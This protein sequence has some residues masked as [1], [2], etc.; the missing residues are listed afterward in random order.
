MWEYAL[1]IAAGILILMIVHCLFFSK[2][3]NW[4]DDPNRAFRKD[5][6]TNFSYSPVTEQQHTQMTVLKGP[7]D[8]M[9]LP[10]RGNLPDLEEQMREDIVLLRKKLGT[11]PPPGKATGVGKNAGTYSLKR[12]PPEKLEPLPP[13]SHTILDPNMAQRMAKVREMEEREK[14]A[15]ILGLK[16]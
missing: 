11:T 7:Y 9:E 3:T 15:S 6:T 14:I 8:E 10:V 4:S 2:K 13:P 16:K 12:Q 1:Y 5:A